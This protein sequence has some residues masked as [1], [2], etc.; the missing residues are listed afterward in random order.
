[1]KYFSIVICIITIFG[2][3]S[4]Y[5]NQVDI[6]SWNSSTINFLKQKSKGKGKSSLYENR[7]QLLEKNDGV[8]FYRQKFIN[9]LNDIICKKNINKFYLI[10]YIANFERIEVFYELIYDN[11]SVI[12]H[13]KNDI[14]KNIKEENVQPSFDKDFIEIINGDNNGDVAVTYFDIE[15][16][17][18]TSK[19]FLPNTL[20][21]NVVH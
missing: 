17:S 7:L 12:Y 16:N 8:I 3:T 20:K 14:W 15:N 11:K 10:E 21:Y 19:Y 18:M 4:N 2:C 6:N 13:L 1:M 5:C 9:H